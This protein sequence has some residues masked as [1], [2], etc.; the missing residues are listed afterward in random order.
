MNSLNSQE[1]EKGMVQI[2]HRLKLF[3]NDMSGERTT[4]RTWLKQNKKD[5]YVCRHATVIN[6][7]ELNHISEQ[8]ITDYP[9]YTDSVLNSEEFWLTQA[10]IELKR[11]YENIQTDNRLN[12]RNNG[13][14]VVNINDL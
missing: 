12:N 7:F 10:L 14:I 4:T 9:T 11:L 1:I 2:N 5:I 8:Q 3:I 6:I 13:R